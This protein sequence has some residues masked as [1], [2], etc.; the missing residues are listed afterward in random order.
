MLSWFV[1][2]LLVLSSTITSWFVAQ[3]SSKFEII[4]M[5][6]V[7]FLVTLTVLIIAFWRPI[8]GWFREI[9]MRPNHKIHK[10]NSL[11]PR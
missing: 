8:F 7:I 9:L 5:V 2:A 4:M 11:R 6:V 1:R 3:D 10:S